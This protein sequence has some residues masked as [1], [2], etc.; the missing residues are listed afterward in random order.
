MK[1]VLL[2]AAMLGTAL[3]AQVPQTSSPPRV[4]LREGLSIVRA[5]RTASGDYEAI[6][7]VTRIDATGVTIAASS[8]ESTDTCRGRSA[9][10]RL[11]MRADLENARAFW[12]EFAAC[13]SEPERHPGSTAVG[14]STAVLRELNAKGATALSATTTV[15][16]LVQG[17]LTRIE[18]STIPFGVVV[19]D[20]PTNLPAVHARWQ[21]SVGAREYW[22]LDDDANPIVLRGTYNG[23]P[24]LEVVKLSYPVDQVTTGAR[25]ERDLAKDKHTIV[26][27]IY[28]DVGSDRIKDASESALADIAKV[29]Q[30]N[31][32]WSLAVE[33]HT[34]NIGGD[35]YNLDL[36]KRRAAAV[37]QVLIG[38]YK[39][40]GKRLQT[41]GWGASRPKDTNATLEG[42]ARNRRVELLRTS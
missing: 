26:Y 39:I 23:N 42:R 1:N 12:Q 40:D 6:A 11:V 27:G 13:P 20:E 10:L 22:I 3:V 5:Y 19:N 41:N 17:S 32:T 37:R 29:L 4:P 34:D 33:G 7:T 16:G 36:S 9:G 21:S 31:P 28:F 2:A 15:A 14:V 35:A 8:D 25:I 24:F 18:R 38:R 30:Q